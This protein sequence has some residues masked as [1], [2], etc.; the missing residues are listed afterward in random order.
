MHAEGLLLVIMATVCVMHIDAKPEMIIHVG[1][2]KTFTTLLQQVLQQVSP[3]FKDSNWVYMAP[4]ENSKNLDIDKDL[5][6]PLR[7]E[8]EIKNV[9][10]VQTYINF[11]ETAA[12]KKKNLIL[13]SQQFANLE[14]CG[15]ENLARITSAFSVTIVMV[16]ELWLERVLFDFEDM[17]QNGFLDNPFFSDWLHEVG[18]SLEDLDLSEDENEGEDS[19]K[20][21]TKFMSTSVLS[22][23]TLL[24][25]YRSAFTKITVLDMH[26]IEAAGKSLPHVLLC[27]IMAVCDIEGSAKLTVAEQTHKN[28]LNH[29]VASVVT[30]ILYAYDCP[31]DDRKHGDKVLQQ[32]WSK[33]F[34]TLQRNLRL[35]AMISV[36]LDRQWRKTAQQIDVNVMHGNPEASYEVST[37]IE[38]V[39]LDRD[40]LL[41]NRDIMK[42]LTAMAKKLKNEKRCQS[43]Q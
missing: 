8:C 22:M 40:A 39:E 11:F 27:D 3:Q 18:D 9:E 30:D 23:E 5:V 35:Y 31:Y 26:G 7:D 17:V 6:I 28:L 12:S 33:S 10:S 13:S 21:N 1:P 20:S 4:G 14:S 2:Q 19:S 25:N 24:Y 16:Y 41:H 42:V 15:I 32:T 36:R 43:K 34:P 37:R 29:Q 38:N